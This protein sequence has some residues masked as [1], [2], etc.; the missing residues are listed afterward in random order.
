VGKGSLIFRDVVSMHDWI[1]IGAST[2]CTKFTGIDL[3]I[4]FAAARPG[5]QAGSRARVGAGRRAGPASGPAMRLNNIVLVVVLGVVY[6][7][8]RLLGLVVA[9]LTSIHRRVVDA[10]RTIRVH[11]PAVHTIS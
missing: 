3:M 1:S 6:G 10:S 2:F 9:H 8:V 4:M 11:A 5:R 7:L